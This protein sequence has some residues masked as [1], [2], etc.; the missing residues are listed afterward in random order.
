MSTTDVG[1]R[2]A[3]GDDADDILQQSLQFGE[4]GS[5]LTYDL[6]AAAA[7]IAERARQ[8][9]ELQAELKAVREAALN[10]RLLMRDYIDSLNREAAGVP[11]LREAKQQLIGCLEEAIASVQLECN[12]V[13]TLIDTVQT[14]RFWKLR[15]F[16]RMFRAKIQRS[17]RR[18]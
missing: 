3:S 17:G 11:E 7:A 16:L 2:G 18:K 14:S 9:Q 15:H 12:A 10:H 4:A 6:E 5:T 1:A 8:V 13:A